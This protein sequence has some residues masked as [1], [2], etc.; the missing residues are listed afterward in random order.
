MAS[1]A[2]TRH[3]KQKEKLDGNALQTT[4]STPFIQKPT[5]KQ[6]WF[7]KAQKA[8]FC[9][10]MK[11]SVLMFGATDKET[12]EKVLLFLGVSYK[13]TKQG[14]EYDKKSLPPFS[15]GFCSANQISHVAGTH[16]YAAPEEKEFA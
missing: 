13:E 9:C 7:E 16:S 15:F 3:R 6:L 4:Q 5:E 1:K 11:N 10:A 12:K 14:Y 2:E 8:G